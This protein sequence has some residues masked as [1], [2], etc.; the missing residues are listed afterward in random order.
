M[1]FIIKYLIEREREKRG[2]VGGFCKLIFK[3]RYLMNFLLNIKL[4]LL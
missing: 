4:G 3:C 1:V 2:I